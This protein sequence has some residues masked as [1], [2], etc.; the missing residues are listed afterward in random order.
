MRFPVLDRSDAEGLARPGPLERRGTPGR[1]E[2]DPPVRSG[3]GRA[4]PP[5]RVRAGSAVGEVLAGVLARPGDRAIDEL[6]TLFSARGPRGRAP[7][8]RSPTSCAPDGR[9]HGHLRRQPQH[10]LHQR[11]HLQVPVLRLLKGPLSLNLRGTPYLLE[12]DEITR[13]VV[14]A[15]AL[16]A[17]EVC[18]QGGIHPTSTATTT[19]T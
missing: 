5:A 6:V 1:R 7:W 15:E 11:V 19:S 4:G 8:P 2:V 16:G 18:L 17:T 10:Q 3:P 9:R 14:E 13:R 12:L